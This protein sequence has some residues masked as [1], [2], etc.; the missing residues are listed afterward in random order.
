M[1]E[2][3]I[4]VVIGPNYTIYVPRQRHEERIVG[5]FLDCALYDFTHFN[6]IDLEELLVKNGRL[7]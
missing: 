6:V 5:Q 2:H 7:K 1:L 3:D 4:G